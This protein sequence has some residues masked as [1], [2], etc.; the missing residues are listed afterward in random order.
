MHAVLYVYFLVVPPGGKVMLAEDLEAEF[1]EP[2]PKP[3]PAVVT[4]TQLQEVPVYHHQAWPDTSD[5]HKKSM[6]F[7]SQP[8]PLPSGFKV[9]MLSELENGLKNMTFGNEGLSEM[10]NLHRRHISS[11]NFNSLLAAA[12]GSQLMAAPGDVLATAPGDLL[13]SASVWPPHLQNEPSQQNAALALN[14]KNDLK[15]F[16]KLLEFVFDKQNPNNNVSD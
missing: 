16:N 10:S 11:E 7:C 6:S 13:N 14:N 3:T 15:A 5:M 12:P 2:V 9:T 4:A 8:A 1:I